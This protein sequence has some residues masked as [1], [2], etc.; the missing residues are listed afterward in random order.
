MQIFLAAV[1]GL[2][3][4]LA[5]TGT[6]AAAAVLPHGEALLPAPAP[7]TVWFHDSSAHAE[8]ATLT[9]VDV[10]GQPFTRAMRIVV[11][12]RVSPDYQVQLGI[13]TAAPVARRQVCLL[14]LWMRTIESRDE[15]TQCQVRVYFQKAGPDWSKSVDHTAQVGT[16]WQQLDLPFRTDAAYAAGKAQ[17]GMAFG[18]REQTV[19]IAA[20]ELIGFGPEMKVADLPR[21]KQDYPGRQADA[22]WRRAATERIARHR[23]ADLTVSVTDAA[24]TPV[25]AA[26][27]KIELV[28]HAFGFGSAVTAHLLK[29]DSPTGQVYRRH[30]LELFNRVVLENDLKWDPWENQWGPNFNRR[31]T[32]EALK[33]LDERGI[34]VHGHVMVWPS[35]RNLPRRLGEMKGD[36]AALRKAV[37]DHIVEQVSLAG[38]FITDWDVIN[39]PFDNHDLM[40]ILGDE[41]MVDWFR[42]ARQ[43]N[44][45][46][47]LMVNDYGILSTGGDLDTPHQAH[48]EKTIRFLLDRGAPVD[49]IGLQGHFGSNVTPPDK[50]EKIIDRFARFGLPLHVTEFDINTIDEQL[51][52]DYTRDFMTVVFSRPE[53]ESFT[54][55]GF[56][57]GAHWKPDAAMFAKDWT[58]KPNA[59]AFRNLVLDE[60]RTR[61][62]VTTDAGGKVMQ[63]G[64]LGEYRVMVTAGGKSAT[65]TVKLPREGA[66]LDVRL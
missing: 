13:D 21:S 43:A 6:A 32:L 27:V 51:Q 42:T 18:A 38:P 31:Q 22:P 4:V 12:R 45:K 58:A 62:E 20:V 9:W 41:V 66:T 65:A 17:V 52:A 44:P 26:Q 28:R 36:H 10:T 7:D 29:A 34:V 1:I 57:E 24:G 46:I 15:T 60:W 33:W 54:M 48:Y 2:V 3:L 59:Q 35:W 37:T 19:E 56:W 53:F 5:M 40:D 50:L 11:P 23:M 55:W 39:E 14:R 8:K 25:P 30:V 49:G 63:R 61:G 64:F 47:R 16:R